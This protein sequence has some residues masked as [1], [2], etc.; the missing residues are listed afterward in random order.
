MIINPG[1]YKLSHE[2]YLADPALD[3]SFLKKFAKSGKHAKEEIKETPAMLFGT[4]FHLAILEPKKFVKKV[5]EKKSGYAEKKK[6][7]YIYLKTDDIQAI[8]AMK[9]NLW[10]KKTGRNILKNAYAKEQ[11][12]FFQLWTGQLAKV[13]I[14]IIA[15]DGFIV[16]LKK[17]N[18]ASAEAFWWSVKKYKYHWQA[19]FYLEAVSKITGIEH[20]RFGIIPSE[21]KPPHEC[22]FY[23]IEDDWLELAWREMQ[24]LIDKYVFCR[25]QNK[26]EGYPDELITLN[27][28]RNGYGN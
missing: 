21:D 28:R 4:C 7:G 3:V 14:D 23:I 18:D 16:D 9:R 2:D 19:A 25:D 26:W 6:D 22:A 8:K 11:C 20:D 10:E 15:P 27:L 12:G 1:F 5:R 13:K 17:T 24:P